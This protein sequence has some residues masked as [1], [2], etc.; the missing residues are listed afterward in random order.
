MLPLCFTVFFFHAEDGIRDGHVTGVQTCALPIFAPGASAE[1][2]EW[3]TSRPNGLETPPGEFST[4][5]MEIVNEGEATASF[6]WQAD[7][8]SGWKIGRASCRERAEN[9]WV[10]L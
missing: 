7:L 2:G 8:P 9:M 1:A 10:S 4:Y 6:Q 5:V 3:S